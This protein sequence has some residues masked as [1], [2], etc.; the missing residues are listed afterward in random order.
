MLR[1]LFSKMSIASFV[2]AAVAQATANIRNEVAAAREEFTNK[3]KALAM[4][5]LLAFFGVGLALFA[6]AFLA[7]AALDALAGVWPTW[8]AALTVAGTLLLIGMIFAIVGV[9]RIRKNADLRPERLVGAYRRF[10][11]DD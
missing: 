2:G 6:T 10:G 11:D 5:A 4:G 1:S 3:I 7:Y 8:L 9:R